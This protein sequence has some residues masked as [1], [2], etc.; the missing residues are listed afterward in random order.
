M[1]YSVIEYIGN[2]SSAY[3]GA[4]KRASSSAMKT[5]DEAKIERLGGRLPNLSVP[6][7]S[8]HIDS[9]ASS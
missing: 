5:A 1:Q 7:I 4:E 8:P 3:R 9:M 2:K 6:I